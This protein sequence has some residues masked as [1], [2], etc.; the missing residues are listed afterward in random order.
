MYKQINKRISVDKCGHMLEI[1][2][3]KDHGAYYAEDLSELLTRNE[4][5]ELK[6]AIDLYLDNTSSD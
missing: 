4:V 6:K 5:V 1:C 3:D 2:I